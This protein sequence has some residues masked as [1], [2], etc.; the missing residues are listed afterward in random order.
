MLISATCPALQASLTASG[1]ALDRLE[2]WEAWRTFKAFLRVEVEGAYDSASL[3][4]HPSDPDPDFGDEACLLLIRQFTERSPASGR[5]QSLGRVVMELRY[6]S[7]HFLAFTATAVWTLDFPTLEEWASVVEGQA[8]FQD[9]MAR[10]PLYTEVYFED[11]DED[12]DEEE[13]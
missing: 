3:Q 9:A 4:F 1:Q 2:P 13:S 10:Q 12:D 7:R 5:D 6:A 11:A 8:C